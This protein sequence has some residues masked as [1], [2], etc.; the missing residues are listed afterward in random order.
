MTR[1]SARRILAVAIGTTLLA[2]PLSAQD[3]IKVRELA[4]PVAVSTDSLGARVSVRAQD[5]LTLSVGYIYGTPT[6]DDKGRLVYQGTPPNQNKALI[7]LNQKIQTEKSV[8]GAGAID[9][10]PISTHAKLIQSRP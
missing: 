7:E 3:N 2:P 6:L 8:T 9:S 5:I 1:Q 4:A 10:A